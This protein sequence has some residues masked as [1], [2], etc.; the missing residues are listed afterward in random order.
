MRRADLDDHLGRLLIL[1]RHVGFETERP[2]KGLTKLAKLD[3]L[4]RYPVFTERLMGNRGL[5]WTLGSE[6][7]E[8][9]R[10]AVTSRMMR[11]KYGPWDDRYYPMLGALIGM[12][13]ISTWRE[14]AAFYI[15]LTFEGKDLAGELSVRDEWAR[16]DARSEFLATNFNLTGSRLKSMIYDELPDVIDRPLRTKI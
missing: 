5:S 9:E 2:L 16:I 10:L 15:A 11:Y 8:E 13:L 4:L 3:F 7:A 14:K 6:P 12:G 1:L